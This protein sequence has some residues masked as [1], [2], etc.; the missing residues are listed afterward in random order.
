[1][2]QKQVAAQKQSAAGMS[3]VKDSGDQTSATSSTEM[4]A[5]ATQKQT[6][7]KKVKS[8]NKKKFSGK[9]STLFSTYVVKKGDSLWWI[10]KYKDIYNDHF[11]WPLIYDANK[12][13]LKDP[14]KIY[15]GQ[16]LMIPRDG[17]KIEDIRKARKKAGAHKP[18]NPPARA[19][20]PVS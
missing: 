13:L 15:P 9:K 20:P 14:N 17:F 19:V 16:K 6:A 4:R 11:L 3:D 10:A 18:Y 5:S 1:M 12:K 7:G 2:D 8:A